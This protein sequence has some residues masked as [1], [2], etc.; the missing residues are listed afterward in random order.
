MHYKDQIPHQ[1]NHCKQYL[2]PVFYHL[3]YVQMFLIQMKKLNQIPLIPIMFF[4]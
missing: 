3:V 1:I 4:L 2:E